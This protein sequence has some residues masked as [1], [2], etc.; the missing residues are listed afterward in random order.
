MSVRFIKVQYMDDNQRSR[1]RNEGLNIRRKTT[2]LRTYWTSLVGIVD[3][4][5]SLVVFDPRVL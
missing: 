3:D 2:Y 4:Q 5:E 1:E